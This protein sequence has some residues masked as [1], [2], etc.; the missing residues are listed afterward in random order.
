MVTDTSGHR[1]KVS[2][3]FGAI[4]YDDGETWPV[5]RL[6]TD[7]GPQR[8][9]DG[10]A[11][12]DEFVMDHSRAEPKGYMSVCQSANGI[13]HLISSAQHYAFNLKWLESPPP[14]ARE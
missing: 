3:L 11:W 12:T 1:R 5:R 9:L 13:I 14:P 4:S 8:K 7:D 6:I 2:G 10:G